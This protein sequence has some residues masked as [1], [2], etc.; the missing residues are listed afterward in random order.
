MSPQPRRPDWFQDDRNPEKD[1]AYFQDIIAAEMPSRPTP[2]PGDV[3][4]R[5]AARYRGQVTMMGGAFTEGEPNYPISGSW[6]P[7]QSR[8][9]AAAPGQQLDALRSQWMG[10]P[11][12]TSEFILDPVRELQEQQ[13]RQTM[14]DGNAYQRAMTENQSEVDRYNRDIRS[15]ERVMRSTR[16]TGRQRQ[17]Q[18]QIAH[19]KDA[20]AGLRGQAEQAL[21][22]EVRQEEARVAYEQ[23]KTEENNKF[24]LGMAELDQK[25]KEA[26]TKIEA[27]AAE[28]ERTELREYREM[29][30][31]AHLQ[32][33]AVARVMI[34]EAVTRHV[35]SDVEARSAR[36]KNAVDNLKPGSPDYQRAIA[37][38]KELFEE[39]GVPW[40]KDQFDSVMNALGKG[41]PKASHWL[42]QELTKK[43]HDVRFAKEMESF[44]ANE[45]HKLV[46]GE[47]PDAKGTYK[48]TS[49][50]E[51]GRRAA[52][53]TIRGNQYARTSR[54]VDDMA[55]AR[56][57]RRDP[58]VVDPESEEAG[59]MVPFERPSGPEAPGAYRWR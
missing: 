2:M 59:D 7:D 52:T 27:E 6:S 29:V 16:A 26:N 51:P 40:D 10:G 57:M 30:L 53:G 41:E 36:L 49:Q 46:T 12:G 20:L 38:V 19:A 45:K 21:Q 39:A 18:G 35:R 3:E 42:T 43:L 28:R 13:Q 8:Q 50:K 4:Q 47:D 15:A 32:P 34:D 24:E 9:M 23:W 48:W 1:D 56:A 37:S 33:F 11:A 17:L 58:F 14:A 44:F 55:R 54:E 25:A 31:Q 5:D 22:E